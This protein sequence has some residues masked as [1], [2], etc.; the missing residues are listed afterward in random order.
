MVKFQSGDHVTLSFTGILIVVC[1]CAVITAASFAEGL[2]KLL[3]PE[4][5]DAIMIPWDTNGYMSLLLDVA[6]RLDSAPIVKAEEEPP[7]VAGS[8]RDAMSEIQGPDGSRLTFR[9]V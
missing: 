7:V 2:L 8:S 5:E 6:H 1:F 9:D 3:G 4:R